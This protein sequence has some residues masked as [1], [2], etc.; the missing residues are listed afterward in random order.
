MLLRDVRQVTVNFT[1][2]RVT[3]ARATEYEVRDA[4][5]EILFDSVVEYVRVYMVDLTA[6]DQD[7]KEEMKIPDYHHDLKNPAVYLRKLGKVLSEPT[8]L[9]KLN[10]NMLRINKLGIKLAE[11]SIED[12]NELNLKEVKVG[13][14]PT[15]IVLIVRYPRSEILAVDKMMK[16]FNP[17]PH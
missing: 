8:Q 10:E 3:T 15:R 1:G 16:E 5:E 14:R 17:Y 11:D 13:E 7:N 6:G 9:L 12:A 2:H 4:L